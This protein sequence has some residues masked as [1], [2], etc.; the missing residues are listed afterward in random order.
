MSRSS[1][2][3]LLRLPDN[4]Q[5]LVFSAVRIGG[6]ALKPLVI[7]TAVLAGRD[8]FAQDYALLISALASV[9]V[10]T[11]GHTH[12]DYYKRRFGA[13][14]SAVRHAYQD[15]FAASLIH[16]VCVLPVVMLAILAWTNQPDLV[17][18]ILLLVILERFYDEE[19]RHFLF[20]REYGR[21]SVAF[22]A[23]LI[24][25]TALT[26]AA[27]WVAG[28]PLV[29]FYVLASGF[30][31][32]G[33]LLLR[34]RHSIF[35]VELLAH[36]ARL[37]RDRGRLLLVSFWRRWQGE[38][39]FN[40]L[41]SFLTVNIYLADRF[42]VANQAGIRIDTYVFF[43]TLFNTAA[44]AHSL[45]YFTP[46]KPHL[47]R[48]G[49]GLAW[50]ELSQP[51][52]LLLP[53][54]LSLA[55]LCVA[56][57]FREL[58][59]AYGSVPLLMLAGMALFFSIQATGLVVVETVFWRVARKQ[60]VAIDAAVLFTIFALFLVLQPPVWA[61]PWIASAGAASRLLLYLAISTRQRT[62]E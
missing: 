62:A 49:A 45:F 53:A 39:A 21:W 51:A 32:I 2:R 29:P 40:Q 4:P 1:K 46:R 8:D 6:L 33:Y 52:N 57:G 55:A 44:I 20:T 37:L 54:G 25:P 10:L 16:L 31:F 28:V 7:F 38:Y 3:S 24:L 30:S 43:A 13:G 15:Y 42:W 56:Y 19:Q 5:L 27:L 36:N 17:I 9:F 26:L 61:L 34:K 48:P 60:L 23:R 41:W 11:H 58:T 50:Q 12:I 18:A 35:Y 47:I 59:P 14:G 22:S